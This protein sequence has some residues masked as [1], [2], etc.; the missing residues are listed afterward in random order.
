M[1]Q[2]AETDIHAQ[3]PAAAPH[4]EFVAKIDYTIDRAR[5]SLIAL[6]HPEGY[7][8][9]ALEANGEMN[10]EF[11]IFNHFMGSVDIELEAKLK[12]HLLDTQN[13]DGSWSLYAGGEG[14]LASTIEAHFALKLAG[15]RAGDEPLLQSRRWILSKG[16]IEKCGTLARFYLACM[17]QV[18]WEATASL[19]VEISLFPNWF[20]FNMYE[21]AS[22]ARGTAFGLML[23][24]ATKPVVPVDYRDG[25]LELYIQPPHFTK[26]KQPPA[27]NLFSL[28]AL[29]NFTDSILRIYDHHH[30]K[31][32]RSRA[33][34]HAENW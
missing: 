5:R 30:F 34:K 3:L 24:Q 9:G 28:R 4:D 33:L 27:P 13:S 14:Y 15:M 25:G 10:A 18:P 20:F 17:G 23:L 22:W 1:S 32:L 29:F 16:G 21:L 31:P 8:H 12:K 26:F 6:Q 7:W 11:I 2:I 19:P